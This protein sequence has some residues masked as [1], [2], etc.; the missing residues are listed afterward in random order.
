MTINESNV[1]NFCYQVRVR[2]PEDGY[3]VGGYT[4]KQAHKIASD[5]PLPHQTSYIP[6]SNLLFCGYEVMMSNLLGNLLGNY[7]VI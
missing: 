1:N 4:L 7:E 5:D 2:R 3:L 6:S